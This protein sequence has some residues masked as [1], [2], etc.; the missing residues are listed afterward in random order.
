M[1][2]LDEI[3]KRIDRIIDNEVKLTEKE[4][5]TFTQKQRDEES[6][7]G[8]GG[9]YRRYEVCINKRQAH[10]DELEV[11]RQQS[12]QGLQMTETLKLYPWACPTCEMVIYLPDRKCRRGGTSEIIDCPVCQR[13]LYRSGAYTTWETIKGSRKTQLHDI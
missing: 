9:N 11:L 8:V 3:R 6:Y 10:L 12:R 7:W 2:T 1:N 5:E 13:T 4:L